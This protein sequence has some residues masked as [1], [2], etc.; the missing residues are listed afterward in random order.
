MSKYKILTSPSSFGQIKS[1]PVDILKLNG[2]E[3]VNNPY[4]RKLKDSEI[5][6]LASECIGVVAG[7]E[8]YNKQV[9]DS[10]P[11]LKCISRVGVGMDSIDLDYAKK[12]KIEILNT[13]DGPTRSVAEFTL[14]IT[15]SLIKKIPQAHYDLKNSVWKKQTG[16]LFKEKILGIIGLGR[17]G[18]TVAKLFKAL[19]LKIIAYDLFP[20]KKWANVNNISLV[21]FDDV[22]RSS[23][24]LT[25]HIPK[26]ETTIINS[27]ALAKMKKKSFLINISRGG[28]VNETDLYNALKEGKIAGA[29][30]DV[31]SEEPYYGNFT[32]L[33]NIILTPHIGSYAEEGKL[34]MEVDAVKNIVNYLNKSL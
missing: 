16:V 25:I 8:N 20:D 33:E 32:E 14:A 6:D 5:I 18:K 13:P 9:I 4:G 23:D 26:S 27:K 3:V 2:Y 17:I 34:G 15:L 1:D 7:V 24:I 28:V 29:A 21:D 30:T 12:K 19:G 22:L 10:L 11:K 31:Y